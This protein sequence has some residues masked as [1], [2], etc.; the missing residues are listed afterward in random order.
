MEE[1]TAV[2][3]VQALD[4]IA[5]ALERIAIETEPG[6]TYAKQMAKSETDTTYTTLWDQL[7]GIRRKSS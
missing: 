2:K 6:P 1:A 3:M 4:R 5:D 7:Q